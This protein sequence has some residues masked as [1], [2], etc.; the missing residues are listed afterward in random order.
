[1][2]FAFDARLSQASTGNLFQDST[3]RSDHYTVAGI[4][5]DLFPT[6]FAKVNVLG[7]YTYYG[8]LFDLSNI[9]YGA[10]LTMIPTSDSSRLVVYITGNVRRRDYRKRDLD[11]LSTNASQFNSADYHA[12]ASMGYEITDAIQLRTG[13]TF[14]STGYGLED[15]SD[16]RTYDLYAGGNISLPANHVL[17]V[18]A[19]Y[20]TGNF[21]FIQD[22]ARSYRIGD[23][24]VYAILSD[25]TLKST[26]LSLRLSRSLGERTGLGLTLSRRRF[27]NLKDEALVYGYSTGLISPWVSVYDGDAAMVSLKTFLVPRL[28]VTAGFGYWEKDH[29]TTIERVYAERFGVL[30]LQPL[31]TAWTFK[32]TDIRRRWQFSVRWPIILTSNRLLEPSLQLDYTDNESTVKVYEYDDFT[33]SG[34]VSFSF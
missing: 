34:G 30:T 18:E 12:L 6:S 7:E 17:D 22:S 31:S 11:S 21:E 2:E 26:Y 20:T 24:L 3:N 1:M 33:I 5:A 13:L 9:Q 10:G 25:G 23:S 19:G 4:S 15:V 27:S 16:R 8:N 28:I 29:P 32:R 14:K